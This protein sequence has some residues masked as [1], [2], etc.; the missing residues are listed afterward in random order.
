MFINKNIYI[1]LGFIQNQAN[2]LQDRKLK[3]MHK[4]C[5]PNR[6]RDSE[7][8][9][10]YILNQTFVGQAAIFPSLMMYFRRKQGRRLRK[11]NKHCVLN[12]VEYEVRNSFR[13]ERK[14]YQKM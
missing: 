10:V 11:A 5:F 1:I 4:T 8:L 7:V 12:L 6:Y 13:S 9:L 14:Q 3:R 2:I